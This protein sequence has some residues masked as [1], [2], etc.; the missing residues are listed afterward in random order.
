MRESKQQVSTPDRPRMTKTEAVLQ[1]ISV[2]GYR[3]DVA[4]IVEYVRTNFSITAESES[5][6]EV[7]RVANTPA[8]DLEPIAPVGR[9]AAEPTEGNKKPAARKTKSKE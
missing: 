5:A 1:A 7:A 2:L 9:P 3:A 4:Q 8:I 6:V